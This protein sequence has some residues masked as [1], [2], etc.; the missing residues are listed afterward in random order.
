MTVTETAAEQRGFVQPIVVCVDENTT[1]EDTVVAAMLAS[2]G[3]WRADLASETPDPAW[4]AWFAGAFTK[5]VRRAKPA[6]F[7]KLTGGHL[8]MFGTAGA[9]AFTPMPAGT[10][11][12]E[13]SRLQVSGTELHRSCSPFNGSGVV[14][15]IVNKSL[16][17]TTGKTC[18]QA[19]HALL[20]FALTHPDVDVTGVSF[21]EVPEDRFVKIA[22]IHSDATVIVDAGR[23]E[24]EPGTATAIAFAD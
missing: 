11:P 7:R 15:V 18:A 4:D 22:A 17:L 14:T 21:A 6:V 24:T 13:L 8:T 3:A 23:T 19:A 12:K 2:V 16:G 20:G 1:H 9:L 5:V 10:L